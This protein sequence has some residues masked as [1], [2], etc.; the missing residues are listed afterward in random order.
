MLHSSL[1][2]FFLW[3]LHRRSPTVFFNLDFFVSHFFFFLVFLKNSLLSLVLQVTSEL[4]VYRRLRTLLPSLFF[5]LSCSTLQRSHALRA[6]HTKVKAVYTMLCV[7][8]YIRFAYSHFPASWFVFY[9]APS[10]INVSLSFCWSGKAGC[11]SERL[12][13]VTALL[14]LLCR[15]MC[16]CVCEDK[17]AVAGCRER[18][19]F[20]GGRDGRE[21]WAHCVQNALFS[22]CLQRAQ[23]S[24][25]NSLGGGTTTLRGEPRTVLQREPHDLKSFQVDGR[26]GHLYL[27]LPSLWLH[28]HE[29]SRHTPRQLEIPTSILHFSWR[30]Q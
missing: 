23:K 20:T 6:T 10:P 4:S 19:E 5:C 22:I 30:R 17:V 26:A 15:D 9:S 11:G 3:N 25:S 14:P 12:H 21:Q 2:L 13:T 1:F 27:L 7:C 29:T 16:V 24:N 18:E 28:A 8:T